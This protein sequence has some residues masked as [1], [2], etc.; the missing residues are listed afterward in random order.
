MAL[1]KIVKIEANRC[2]W[3]KYAEIFYN[4][5]REIPTDVP[6]GECLSCD[7]HKYHC[8]NYITKE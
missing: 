8:K 4:K 5:H 2:D 6:L 1:T 3:S 7:G